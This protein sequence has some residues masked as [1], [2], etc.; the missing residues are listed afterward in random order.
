MEDIRGL[1]CELTSLLSDGIKE[2]SFVTLNDDM[3][4]FEIDHIKREYSEFEANI[5][6]K[7]LKV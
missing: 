1:I 6:L 2:I 5:Y 3:S 4:I 7:R